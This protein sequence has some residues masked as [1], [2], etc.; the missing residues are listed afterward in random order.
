MTESEWAHIQMRKDVLG[1]R[2]EKAEAQTEKPEDG[3][4]DGGTTT[5]Q[6]L[7]RLGAIRSHGGKG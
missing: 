4:R 2:K 5:N 1:D 7:L 3:G 6:Q